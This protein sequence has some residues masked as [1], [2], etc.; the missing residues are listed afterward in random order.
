MIEETGIITATDGTYA[1][2]ETRRASSCGSCDARPTCGTSALARVFGNRSNVVE[3]LNPI[4]A[5]TGESVVVG[6]EE[7]AFTR[8]SILFYI[9]PLFA[10]FAGGLSGEWLA[11]QLGLGTTEPLSILC[12]LLGLSAGLYWLRRFSSSHRRNPAYQAVILRRAGP[13]QIVDGIS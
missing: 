4:G 3:V 5:E 1:S 7:S 6:I 10:L 8:V 12:G 11:H 13:V 9:L 2:V